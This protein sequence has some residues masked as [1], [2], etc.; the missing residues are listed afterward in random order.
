MFRIPRFDERAQSTG[1]YKLR[2][3]GSM[4]PTNLGPTQPKGCRNKAREQRVKFLGPSRMICLKLRLCFFFFFWGGGWVVFV[5]CIRYIHVYIFAV[6][7]TFF[8]IGHWRDSIWIHVGNP[9]PS[10]HSMG[11]DVFVDCSVTFEETPMNPCSSLY[12]HVKYSFFPLF[13]CFSPD[14]IVGS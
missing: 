9:C 4:R 7:C 1:A 5:Y 8:W 12:L 14:H 3:V 10:F 13:M 2:S 11:W 6:Y